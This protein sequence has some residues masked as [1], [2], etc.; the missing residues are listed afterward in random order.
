MHAHT[1]DTCVCVWEL[2]YSLLVSV[3]LAVSGLLTGNRQERR[4]GNR[5]VKLYTDQTCSGSRALPGACS[6]A[7]TWT[8]TAGTCA[9]G[10]T[11][12]L[13]STKLWG[14]HPWGISPTAII[15]SCEDMRTW[16]E[17]RTSCGQGLTSCGKPRPAQ[18]RKSRLPPPIHQSSS[19]SRL[20]SCA[21]AGAHPIGRAAGASSVPSIHASRSS[22]SCKPRSSSS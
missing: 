4:T 3:S 15:E 7:D 8:W 17:S 6:C 21:G 16:C 10:Y 13:G 2:G 9:P 5:R 14:M 12:V 19:S 11:A 18:A 22:A 20:R 1:P